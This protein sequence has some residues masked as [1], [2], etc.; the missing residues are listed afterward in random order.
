MI[1]KEPRPF[2]GVDSVLPSRSHAARQTP[3][4]SGRA[5]RG[6]AL[7]L[8]PAKR[9]WR[10]AVLGGSLVSFVLLAAIASYSPRGPSG[11]SRPGGNA[12]GIAFASAGPLSYGEPEPLWSLSEPGP[13]GDPEA[14]DLLERDQ[15]QRIDSAGAEPSRPGALAA[16]S[17][18][19][20]KASAAGRDSGEAEAASRETSGARGA[21]AGT[22][23]RGVSARSLR[24][25]PVVTELAR[26]GTRTAEVRRR[27]SVAVSL[28]EEK[29][30]QASAPKARVKA[31]DPVSVVRPP[32]PYPADALK[33]EQEGLVRVN[34]LVGS[35]GTVDRVEITESQPPGVFDQSVQET[36]KQWRFTPA[37]DKDGKPMESWEMD[38]YEFA[39]KLQRTRS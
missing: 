35:T 26:G 12:R 31:K 28:E 1:V 29:S 6:R 13:Y 14:S 30:I 34:L 36:L 3:R 33:S 21:A 38:T 4:E 9:G 32:P 8:I 20:G 18:K 10:L 37:R 23:T 39:F 11:P 7:E 27:T 25:G 2:R 24:A 5:S 17:R 16:E 15:H 19:R 22:A